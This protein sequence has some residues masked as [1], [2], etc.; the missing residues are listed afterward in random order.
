MLKI[1]F[2]HTN[3]HTETSA[4][5]INCVIDNSLVKTM[6]NSDQALIELKLWVEDISPKAPRL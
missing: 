1:S 5:L 2:F 3:I 6:P 4:P